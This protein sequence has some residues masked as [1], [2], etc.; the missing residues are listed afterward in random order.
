MH[1]L[2]LPLILLLTA[3]GGIAA[4]TG[5]GEAADWLWL[6]ATLPVLV[7]LLL[8]SLRKLRRGEWGV[9]L[10]A[11]LA[12]GGALLLGQALTAAV[13]ALMFAGGQALESYAA[14]RARR[15]LTALLAR[16]PA[17]VERQTAGAWRT[18]P[19]AEVQAGDRL[20]VKTGAVLPVDGLVAAGGP[21][22]L[23]ESS[24]TG[25]SLPVSHPDGEAVASGTLNVGQGFELTAL[26]AAADSTYA[27]I[28]RL[29]RQLFALEAILQLHFDQENE[30]YAGL[31]GEG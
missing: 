10:V 27:A 30:L 12:M 17:T 24:L 25:E 22:S 4:L 28:V 14:N 5:A 19:V 6:L 16:T 2:L 9:D 23:D 8:E 13:I 20:L 15:E 26:R 7:W 18:V 1:K 29:V 31:A 21:I 3:T 11:G